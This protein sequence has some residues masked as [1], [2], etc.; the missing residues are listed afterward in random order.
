MLRTIEPLSIT[1]EAEPLAYIR[2]SMRRIATHG[3]DDDHSTLL[4]Q[5][6]HHIVLI[7]IMSTDLPLKCFRSSNLEILRLDI[8][9]T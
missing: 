7:D 5:S 8:H 3:S 2:E 9:P 4:Q 1:N 6:C